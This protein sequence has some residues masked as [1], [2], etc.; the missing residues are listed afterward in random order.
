MKNTVDSTLL[1]DL[2]VFSST[3]QSLL[4]NLQR[5]LKEGQW[6]F[7]Q[8]SPASERSPSLDSDLKVIYTPNPE[9]VVQSRGDLGFKRVLQEADLLL[10][11]GIGLVLASRFLAKFDKAQPIAERIAGVDVVADLL[12]MAHQLD[13]EVLVVG[14]R[15]YSPSDYFVYKGLK[16]NWTP[17]FANALQ[18]T[19]KEQQQLDKHIKKIKPTLVFV[20]FGAPAQELWLVENR[21]LLEE[22]GVR[23]A[24]AVGGSFDYLLGKVP[25]APFWWQKLGLEWFY[26]LLHQ[27]WRGKR[28]LRLVH[29]ILLTLRT[30][31]I[32]K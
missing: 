4:K 15:D 29:F 19:K 14:G 12:E 22:S 8:Q 17:G 9:Q 5:W 3:K 2:N 20:A 7:S 24:M 10:P 11:D 27:P 28:Q 21:A 16:V 6:N 1:F 31:F 26:R 18:P 23:I 32:Q 25:R 30:A 13:G